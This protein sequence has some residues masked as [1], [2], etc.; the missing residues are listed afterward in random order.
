MRLY[1]GS[2]SQFSEDVIQNRIADIV[3]KKYK[4]HYYLAN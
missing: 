3:E 1:E 4:L 2:I